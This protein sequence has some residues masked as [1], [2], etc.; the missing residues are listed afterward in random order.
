M[1]AESAHTGYELLVV[2]LF[3]ACYHEGPGDSLQILFS[4]Y[5]N[6]P[7]DDDPQDL[8]AVA[9]LRSEEGKDRLVFS[10]LELP[11]R[12]LACRNREDLQRAYDIVRSAR[13]RV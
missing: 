7:G 12:A 5:P 3:V 6:V 13:E 10:A 9:G 11:L 4:L 8:V 2:G 1:H